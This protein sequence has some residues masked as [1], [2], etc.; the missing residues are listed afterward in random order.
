MWRNGRAISVPNAKN[1]QAAVKNGI[2]SII[3]LDAAAS[4]PFASI[5]M[6]SAMFIL[7]LIVP[8][9]FLGRWLY[10]T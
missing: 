4:M 7:V 10:S 8:A 5:G 2:M 9:N 1:V 3:V 6:F